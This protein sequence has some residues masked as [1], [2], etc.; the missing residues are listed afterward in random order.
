MSYL[1]S[2]QQQHSNDADGFS[3]AVLNNKSIGS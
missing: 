1:V 2:N 3:P